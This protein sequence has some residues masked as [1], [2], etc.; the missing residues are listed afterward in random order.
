MGRVMRHEH[1]P[2]WESRWVMPK[3]SI[4]DQILN[5]PS[6]ARSVYAVDTNVHPA[7][8]VVPKLERNRQLVQSVY[9]QTQGLML[10]ATGRTSETMSDPLHRPPKYIL[11]EFRVESSNAGRAR[12]FIRPAAPGQV[13]WKNAYWRVQRPPYRTPIG[14]FT[15]GQLEQQS[16]IQRMSYWMR[17]G[18][19]S[20]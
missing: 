3:S 16:I 11:Q 14:P 17:G 10:S 15:H 12:G 2:N 13:Q 20:Q 8:G 7:F 18:N 9:A 4:L 6:A 5:P 19:T 1:P